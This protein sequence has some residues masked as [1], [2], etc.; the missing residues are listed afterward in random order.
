MESKAV[1]FEQWDKAYGFG[2]SH[3]LAQSTRCDSIAQAKNLM[4]QVFLMPHLEHEQ[5]P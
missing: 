4:P 5:R 2:L 3:R 1:G